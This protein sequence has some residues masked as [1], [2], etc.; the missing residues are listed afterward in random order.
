[1]ALRRLKVF[2]GSELGGNTAGKYASGSLFVLLWIVYIILS[3]LKSI[4]TL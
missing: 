4:G 2:G 1:M 3:S